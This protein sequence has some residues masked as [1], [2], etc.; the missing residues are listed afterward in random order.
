MLF[1]LLLFACIPSVL[2][3]QMAAGDT[4]TIEYIS[5]ANE[6]WKASLTGMHGTFPASVSD[7]DFIHVGPAP[8]KGSHEDRW[9]N[10]IA[11]DGSKWWSKCHS[12][13]RTFSGSSRISFTFEHFR[14]ERGHPG[15][16]TDHEDTT[17]GFIGWDGT[18]WLAT[19]PDSSTLN[20]PHFNIT[21]H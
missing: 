4:S 7:P 5:G 21:K 9:I 17:L 11:W 10:Y 16:N 13:S 12:H 18:H 3:A 1:L 20:P 2:S 6:H 14:D 19:V 15:R 8:G